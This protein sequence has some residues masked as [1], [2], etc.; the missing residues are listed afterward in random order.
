MLRLP[1]G[2]AWTKQ[3]NDNFICFT[4]RTVFELIGVTFLQ[5]RMNRLNKLYIKLEVNVCVSQCHFKKSNHFF[6][7]VFFNTSTLSAF[8]FLS[9]KPDVECTTFHIFFLLLFWQPSIA[10]M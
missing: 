3:K 1:V 6:D 10:E 8:D 9:L 5:S 4:C 7:V 2:A